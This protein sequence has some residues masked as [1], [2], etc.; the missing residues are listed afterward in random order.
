[1]KTIVWGFENCFTC[2]AIKRLNEEKIID[3][4]EW[5]GTP[6]SSHSVIATRDWMDVLRKQEEFSFEL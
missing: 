4:R 3:V 2:G 5:F 6:E 1:M